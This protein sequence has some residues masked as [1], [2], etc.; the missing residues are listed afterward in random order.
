MPKSPRPR[1]RSVT[2]SLTPDLHTHL[3]RQAIEHATTVSQRLRQLLL[4]NL[5]TKREE[6]QDH[7]R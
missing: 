2:V 4:E 1:F 6:R 5:Q 7:A 3:Q